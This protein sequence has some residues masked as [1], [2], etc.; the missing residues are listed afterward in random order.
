L[1]KL[2]GEERLIELAQMLG[3]LSEGTLQSARELLQTA[4]I[5][6]PPAEASTPEN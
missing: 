3:G 2:E 1:K 6:M 4:Q 5:Q